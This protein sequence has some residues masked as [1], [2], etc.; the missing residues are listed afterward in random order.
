MGIFK[1]IRTEVYR[2]PKDLRLQVEQHWQE[3]ELKFSSPLEIK[4]ELDPDRSHLERSPNILYALLEREAPEFVGRICPFYVS[5][6]SCVRGDWFQNNQLEIE[7]FHQDPEFETK[8]G[9]GDEWRNAM[10]QFTS[11]QDQDYVSYSVLSTATIRGGTLRGYVGLPLTVDFFYPYNGR[12]ETVA[13][14]LRTL[15]YGQ[16]LDLYPRQQKEPF[17]C[18]PA[19][20]NLSIRVTHPTVKRMKKALQ[21]VQEIS[22][23]VE[24]QQGKLRPLIEEVETVRQE[25]ADKKW[26]YHFPRG[27]RQEGLLARIMHS[28]DGPAREKLKRTGEQLHR[29]SERSPKEIV[30]FAPL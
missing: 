11:Y 6:F 26:N 15:L 12:S 8:G 18:S 25:Y 27:R 29:L 16:E 1:P 2:L 7:Y 10:L 5:A 4:A 21:Q 19:R 14:V 28:C 13:S 30:Q 22:A 17:D 20:S 23:F 9:F 3:T 24:E